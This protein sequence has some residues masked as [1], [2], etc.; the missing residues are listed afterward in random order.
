MHPVLTE[1][2]RLVAELA[3]VSC[4]GLDVLKA[5]RFN[6]FLSLFELAL[7][8]SH[9]HSVLLQLLP[10]ILE[11]LLEPRELV[12]DALLVRFEKRNLLAVQLVQLALLLDCLR[13]PVESVPFDV[14]S[15]ELFA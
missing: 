3:D 2:G 1:G 9:F 11:I 4:S 10:L 6:G 7:E 5:H 12:P 13:F 15:L 14:E 8:E